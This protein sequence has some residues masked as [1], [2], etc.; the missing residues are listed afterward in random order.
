MIGYGHSYVKDFR[1]EMNVGSSFH[2]R[3]AVASGRV[4][5]E[6]IRGGEFEGREVYY[7]I[8]TEYHIGPLVNRGVGVND[9]ET[10][11]VPA[12][13]GRA[14]V[15]IPLNGPGMSKVERKVTQFLKFAAQTHDDQHI[16]TVNEWNRKLFPKI[17]FGHKKKNGSYRRS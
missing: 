7:A 15:E 16:L 3:A 12:L 2:A 9:A 10:V 5:K 13:E 17:R 8:I 1:Y 14:S 4:V 6:R 11:V